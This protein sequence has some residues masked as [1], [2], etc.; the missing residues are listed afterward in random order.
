[1][2]MPNKTHQRFILTH[3]FTALIFC[4]QQMERLNWCCCTSDLKEAQHDTPKDF[5]GNIV[6]EGAQWE[7]CR[8]TQRK[9]LNIKHGTHKVSPCWNSNS[10]IAYIE[11]NQIFKQS[12][13]HLEIHSC[14]LHLHFSSLAKGLSNYYS[15]ISLSFCQICTFFYS[16][17]SAK[18]THFLPNCLLPFKVHEHQAPQQRFKSSQNIQG[19][20][21]HQ[22]KTNSPFPRFLLFLPSHTSVVTHFSCNILKLA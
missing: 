21:W 6:T 13:P 4:H 11:Q 2:Q 15:H 8:K 16:E 12:Q 14:H 7:F 17:P 19:I 1:M 9:K 18:T 5:P 3:N 20:Y 22:I 10:Q